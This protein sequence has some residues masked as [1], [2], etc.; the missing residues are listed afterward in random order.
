MEKKKKVGTKV[1]LL[2]SCF[3]SK[4]SPG[5]TASLFVRPGPAEVLNLFDWAICEP[6]LE[7]RVG[8]LLATEILFTVSWEPPWSL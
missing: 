2:M 4:K 3:I 5:L 6:E 7:S 8:V 1:N